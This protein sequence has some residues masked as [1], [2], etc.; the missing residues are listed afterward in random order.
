MS[1]LLVLAESGLEALVVGHAGLASLGA[2]V[3]GAIDMRRRI[4][5][6]TATSPTS[7]S[8]KPVDVENV[9]QLREELQKLG[10]KRFA[11]YWRDALGDGHVEGSFRQLDEL[12]VGDFE[13]VTDRI[14]LQ[15][16]AIAYDTRVPPR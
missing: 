9:E 2:F 3:M 1:A 11:L 15:R 14:E 6:E 16:R 10:A 7:W 12:S 4:S 13:W 5:L 8:S